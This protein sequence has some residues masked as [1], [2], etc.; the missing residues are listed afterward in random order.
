[1]N[2]ERFV[3]WLENRDTH[4]ISEADRARRHAARCSDCRQLLECDEALDARLS[5]L[6]ARESVPKRL[7]NTID[8]NLDSMQRPRRGLKI[9][10]LVATL[11]I[12]LLAVIPF[13]GWITGQRGEPSLL[14]A[15]QL[16]NYILADYR[17]H[18]GGGPGFEQVED[19]TLWLNENLHTRQ[20]PP[21]RL[22]GG[23]KVKLARLCYLGKCLAVHLIY[24]KNGKNISVFIMNKENVEAGFDSDRLYTMV[25]GGKHILIS[26]QRRYLYAAIGL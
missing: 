17:D 25:A 15:E 19:A 22:V 24:E 26:P 13:Q 11:C 16:S 10:P 20:L 21:E 6:F 9:W 3:T 2:C 14:S 5:V 4:D 12:V 7:K 8:L 18:G 23:Y 1:M